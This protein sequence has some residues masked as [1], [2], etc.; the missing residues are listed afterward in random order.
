M[1]KTFG[2]I[3]LLCLVSFSAFAA[4][5]DGRTTVTSAG[6]AVALS[7]SALPFVRVTICAETDN[8][9]IIAVGYAPVAAL[10]T[11]AGVPLAAGDCYTI[12]G[13]IDGSRQY[14]SDIK[15]DSTVSTDGV[16]YSV[17]TN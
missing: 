1:K 10:S 6:T 17:V 3:L 13:T 4:N 14:L 12:P 11:R 5:T 7:S 8:T 2:F 9:G 15:I 16:T